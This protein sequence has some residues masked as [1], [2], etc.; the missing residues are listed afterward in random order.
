MEGEG[1]NNILDGG[2]GDNPQTVKDP[3]ETPKDPKLTP[4]TVSAELVKHLSLYHIKGPTIQVLV[5]QGF[6]SI[7][8]LRFMKEGDVP[9]L[10]AGLPMAQMRAMEAAVK[11]L[12]VATFP[13]TPGTSTAPSTSVGGTKVVGGAS[14]K[15]PETAA[16]DYGALVA[17]MATNA[18]GLSLGKAPSVGSAQP[19]TEPVVPAGSKPQDQGL[20]SLMTLLGQGGAATP[21]TGTGTCSQ[22]MAYLFPNSKITYHKILDFV[23]VA[24]GQT[25]QVVGEEGAMQLV[26]KSNVQVKPKLTE[27][28]P[29]QWQV[30]NSRICATLLSEGKLGGASLMGYLAHQAK[31]GELAS[32]YT[33]TSVMLWDDEFRKRQAE[34]QLP[35]GSDLVHLNHVHLKER[36]PP[37]GNGKSGRANSVNTSNNGNTMGNKGQQ[38]QGG[39]KPICRQYNKGEC[40]FEKCSYR[41]VCSV[42]GCGKTHKA[43]EH[44]PPVPA[45]AN[46]TH[47]A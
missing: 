39:G 8:L 34:F 38:K 27:V 47:Y 12:R 9:V 13:S 6:T 22:A 18:A 5:Q 1:A 37:Q 15:H 45:T 36:P 29:S 41:H 44:N 14:A 35:W 28:T 31:V 3:K 7:A 11:G 33:W 32:R 4:M 17:A 42:A 21:M 30:A 16:S 43:S 2:L 46:P 20:D 23:S 40:L 25:D 10:C 26:I 24:D 19:Q